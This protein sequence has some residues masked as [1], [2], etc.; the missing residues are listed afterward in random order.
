MDEL[1]EFRLKGKKLIIDLKSPLIP[2]TTYVINFGDAIVDL[3]EGNKA[4]GLQYVFS[5]G[6]FLD[7][8]QFAA[9]VTN[10]FDQKP[11][12]DILVML[13][14][15]LSDTMPYKG[16]PDY[17]GKTD[18]AGNVVIN[19]I[20]EG[21]YRAIALGDENSNYKYNP[22]LEPIG[23]AD[24]LITPT[25]ADSSAIPLPF[26]LFLPEDTI[27]YIADTKSKPYGELLV[28]FHQPADSVAVIPLEN[29]QVLVTERGVVG[30]SLWI[31]MKNRGDFPDMDRTRLVINSDSSLTDTVKWNLSSRKAETATGAM[32]LRDN[33]LYNFNPH[34]PVILKFNHPIVAIDTGKIAV[35]RDSV[36]VD[37]NLKRRATSERIIEIH[38]EWAYGDPYRIFIPEGTF[39]DLFGLTNDTLDKTVLMR[40]DRYFG[41]LALNFLYDESAPVIL[42]LLNEKGAVIK[43]ITPGNPG[44]IEF[45]K[46][47]PGGYS[48]RVIEDLNRNGVWDTGNFDQKL[49]PEPVNVFP[50]TIQV[51]S[52]WDMEI[53]WDLR[54]QATESE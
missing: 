24:S 6:E 17:F 1:P 47:L 23:F 51:R 35:F 21:K 12:K 40:P 41:K 49:Q 39:T 42:Q 20:R 10:A 37:F 13:Y 15:N 25:A 7:S 43:E 8:L 32:E 53:E 28:V 31:W 19:F 52:N 5:T 11:E 2:S 3:T 34:N 48:A 30:D 27:Q 54:Q 16:I 29:E 26:R 18:Q 50:S 4:A 33:L 44:V 45:P 9:Q 22:P 36:E 46:L 38:H 14:S